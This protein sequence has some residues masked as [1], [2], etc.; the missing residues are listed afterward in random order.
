MPEQYRRPHNHER[1]QTVERMKHAWEAERNALAT[2]RRFNAVLSAK[3]YA[4]FWPKIAAAITAKH[5]WLVI[6]C[7]SCGCV[8]D[9]DLRVKPRDPSISVALRDV[10]CPLQWERATTHCCAGG[11]SV[12]LEGR[13]QLIVRG[14]YSMTNDVQWKTV[15]DELKKQG[16][17]L[18]NLIRDTHA[19]TALILSSL[20]ENGFEMALR[21]AMTHVSN[22][23][24]KRLLTGYG[25]LSNF[26]AKIDIAYGMNLITGKQRSDANLIR[27]IRNKFAHATT[28][29]DFNSADIVQI[30]RHLSTYDAEKNDVL[31]AYMKSIDLISIQLREEIKKHLTAAALKDA[32]ARTASGK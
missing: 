4:W 25:P 30:G 29:L 1:I 31:A 27:N 2:V 20:L 32:T 21:A 6:L 7:E 28:K 8:T 3:G 14:S 10:H 9:L 16:I 17:D 18:G 15:E 19:G 13:S 23:A 11:A 24:I 22:H 26:S 12:D 5:P